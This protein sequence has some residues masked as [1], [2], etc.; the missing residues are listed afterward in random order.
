MPP[1]NT[2]MPAPILS[3]ILPAK[4]CQIP[5]IKFWKARPIANTSLPHWLFS[6]IGIKNIPNECLM[7][8]A[9]ASSTEPAINT[10]IGCLKFSNT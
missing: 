5:H 9:I 8:N 6:L 10:N 7:P 1:I 3:E 4:G 2:T